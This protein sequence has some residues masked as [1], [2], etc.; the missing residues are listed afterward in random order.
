MVRFQ[1]VECGIP[2]RLLPLEIYEFL[3]VDVSTVAFK[4]WAL[5]NLPGLQPPRV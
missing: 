2:G 4:F 1:R 3:L 5:L